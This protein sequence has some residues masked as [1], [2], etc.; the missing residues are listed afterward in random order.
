MVNF[1]NVRPGVVNTKGWRPTSA[2]VATNPA[3]RDALIK[4][5][6]IAGRI[7]DHFGEV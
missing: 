5:A 7:E 2:F 3:K 1:E 6:F 4:K